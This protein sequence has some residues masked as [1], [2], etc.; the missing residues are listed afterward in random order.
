MFKSTSK[1]FLSVFL[2]MVLTVGFIPIGAVKVVAVEEAP[3]LDLLLSGFNIL[4]GEELKRDKLKPLLDV[5]NPERESSLLGKFH[6]PDWWAGYVPRVKF[7][8][9]AAKSVE[10]LFSQ[11]N[12]STSLSV[13]AKAGYKGLLMKANVSTQFNQDKSS[14]FSYEEVSDSFFSTLFVSKTL[15][16]NSMGPNPLGNLRRY[17]SDLWNVL[18]EGLKEALLNSTTQSEIYD[19][20]RNYGT[21]IIASYNVGGYLDKTATI[22]NTNRK[23]SS[24]IRS[25][26][27]V[28]VGADFSGFG[29]SASVDTHFK[30]ASAMKQ[31]QSNANMETTNSIRAVGGDKGVGKAMSS[32]D[33]ADYDEWWESIERSNSDIVADDSLELIGIWEILPPS[34]ARQKRWLESAFLHMA[35]N[36]SAEFFDEFIYSKSNEPLTTDLREIDKLDNLEL[37]AIPGKITSED[38]LKGKDVWRVGTQGELRTAL[39]GDRYVILTQDIN[40][41]DEWSPIHEFGG[42]LDGNGYKIKNLRINRTSN[43]DR[44]E[45]G[46]FGWINSN[47]SIKNLDIELHPNGI[48]KY[49]HEREEAIAGALIGKLTSWTTTTIEN[50]SVSGGFGTLSPAYLGTSNIG[51]VAHNY[52]GGAGYSAYAFAGGL[53]GQVS[54]HATVTIDNCNVK[55]SV[56]SLSRKAHA[57]GIGSTISMAGGFIGQMRPRS[58]VHIKNSYVDKGVV[59]AVATGAGSFTMAGGFVGDNQNNGGT[60]R[61]E[62]SYVDYTLDYGLSRDDARNQIRT[63][64]NFRGDFEGNNHFINLRSFNQRDIRAYGGNVPGLW[65]DSNGQNDAWKD[66]VNGVPV[67]RSFRNEFVVHYPNG[68]PTFEQ[69]QVLEQNLSEHGIQIFY[70]DGKTPHKDVTDKIN[71]A[72][73]FNEH[74]N[75]KITI[76]HF[77]EKGTLRVGELSVEVKAT[78]VES[79]TLLPPT[80]IR[81]TIGEMFSLDGLAWEVVY[82]NGVLEIITQNELIV[83]DTT[84]ITAQESSSGIPVTVT[85]RNTELAEKV[86]RDF[87]LVYVSN[88]VLTGIEV[89]TQSPPFRSQYYV[90]QSFNPAGVTIMGVYSDESRI[91]MSLDM[92]NIYPEVFNFAVTE[93][94]RIA[95]KME[96]EIYNETLTVNVVADEIVDFIIQRMPTKT[97]YIVGDFL[98]LTG[99]SA[100]VQRTSG[101]LYRIN[102]SHLEVDF[103]KGELME[104]DTFARLRYPC[105][106]GGADKVFENYTFVT[107]T[108]LPKVNAQAPLISGQPQNAVVRMAAA[109]DSSEPKHFFVVSANSPDGGTLSYQWYKNSTA[110]TVGGTIINEETNVYFGAPVNEVGTFYYYVEVTNTIVDNDDGGTKTAKTLSDVATLVVMEP[111]SIAVLLDELINDAKSG[112]ATAEDILD[113]VKEMGSSEIQDALQERETLDKL[114]ELEQLFM[115]KTE[116]TIEIDVATNTHGNFHNQKD[117]IQIVGAAFNAALQGTSISLS[118]TKPDKEIELDLSAFNKSSAIQVEIDLEGATSSGSLDIPVLITVPIPT[119]VRSEDFW[120]LH[121]LKDGTSEMIQPIINDDGTCSFSVTSFSQFVF[122]NGNVKRGAIAPREGANTP[123]GAADINYLKGY[124]TSRPGFERNDQMDCNRDGKINIADLTYL[125][126]YIVGANGF[127]LET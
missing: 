62:N 105:N 68:K 119:G 71:I 94:I 52:E 85:H 127:E 88:A 24:D 53:I 39:A 91:P 96:P 17:N 51:I 36:K 41:T 23:E 4:S 75:S 118:F 79:V 89:Q 8:H 122:V 97:E 121:Q 77:D 10:E 113:A 27:D 33:P 90:G 3:G 80:K 102:G 73:N 112:N 58:T 115:E 109:D 111:A 49:N 63:T 59:R 92:V 37:P 42:T 20:F 1:K 65:K 114:I 106:R 110:N 22:V 28:K 50:V 61:I 125:K 56:S 12:I 9:Y 83:S 117:K 101:E 40:L 32:T 76:F 104:L 123:I 43:N 64:H 82:S 69:G 120:I 44:W 55:S 18:D 7:E 93:T 60:L 86:D 6:H 100:L 13:D 116:I 29:V 78:T 14:E 84:D 46:L 98:D 99:F 11:K 19:L 25:N 47:I 38:D 45:A 21:H 66:G 35:R 34:E 107:H 95:D 16:R 30:N 126:Y 54:E 74:G 5:N 15:G 108:S 70:S 72:Y 124:L 103:P 48:Y 81:Y 67:L 2:A 57:G 87:F 31:M 26:M